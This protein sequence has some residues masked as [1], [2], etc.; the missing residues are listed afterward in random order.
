MRTIARIALLAVAFATATLAFGWWSV[1]GVGIF[2]GLVAGPGR[3]AGR[4][5]ALAASLGW[6]VLL[7]V[8][9]LQGPVLRVADR[10]G[11]VLGVPWPV[12]V[13]ITLLFPAVLGG[14]GAGVG[15]VIR[16]GKGKRERGKG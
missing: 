7:V 13:G 10:V 4:T 11:G 9:A 12:V 8:T 16:E 3:H 6:L 2:W 1:A 15:R 5:A 14:V